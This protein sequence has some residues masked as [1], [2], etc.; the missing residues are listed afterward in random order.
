MRHL[1]KRALLPVIAVLGTMSMN[2]AQAAFDIS[3]EA[4]GVLNSTASFSSSG[5]ETFDSLSTGNG[6]TFT[7]T[8]GGTGISGTFSGVNIVPANQYGGAGGTGNY[9]TDGAGSF[10][11]TLGSA[12]TYFGLWISALNSTN[13]LSFYSNGVLVEQFTPID[14]I[15]LVSGQP[16]YYGN[17]SGTY[18]GQDGSEPFAFT[19]FY[20]T[21][22]TF[23]QIVV[24]GFGFES[25]NYTVGTFTAQAGTTVGAPE[26]ISI[27][28]LG[29]G[30]A[31]L[32]IAKRRKSR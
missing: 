9:A 25:D 29:T 22:G 6:Q 27:A 7:S 28:L 19:N 26:P 5:V 20:D 3:V 10:T 11:V 21:T 32:G 23:N 24:S 13:N 31:G 17:P 12:V 14:L 18:A 15:N 4:A 30:L 16:A 1:K 8:F 2:P